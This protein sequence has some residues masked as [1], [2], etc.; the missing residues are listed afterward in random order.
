M[1]CAFVTNTSLSSQFLT[2]SS[3]SLKCIPVCSLTNLVPIYFLWGPWITVKVI[4]HVVLICIPGRLHMRSKE[5]N[6]PLA[7]KMVINQTEHAVT[8]DLQHFETVLPARW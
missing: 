3:D 1:W 8:G 4:G 7:L 5:V 6:S 2:R